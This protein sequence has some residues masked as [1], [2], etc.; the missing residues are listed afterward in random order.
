[1]PPA[2]P[3][4][5]LAESRPALKMMPAP[6]A[7]SQTVGSYVQ[8]YAGVESQIPS[9]A[10]FSSQ[11]FEPQ[12]LSGLTTMIW[13]SKSSNCAPRPLIESMKGLKLAISRS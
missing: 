4:F 6:S 13:K 8:G 2:S 11:Y 12:Y 10:H 9:C 1:M 7:L 3:Q 5:L